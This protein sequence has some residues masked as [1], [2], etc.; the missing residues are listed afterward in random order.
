MPTCDVETFTS[1]IASGSVP[2]A[3]E[4]TLH[5]P[6]ERHSADAL[7]TTTTVSVRRHARKEPQTDPARTILN[8]SFAHHATTAVTAVA[9]AQHAA[10]KRL[11][12]PGTITAMFGA[13]ARHLNAARRPSW[14]ALVASAVAAGVLV[15]WV[16]I[17]RQPDIDARAVVRDN[18]AAADYAVRDGRYSEPT[19]RS[20]L[21]YYST[22]LAIDPMNVEAISGIDRIAD[23]YIDDA[24]RLILDGQY[25]PAALALEKVR[26]IRPE[27]RR[28]PLLDAQLRKELKEILAQAHEV[29][30]ARTLRDAAAKEAGA[31]KTRRQKSA[32]PQ[33]KLS[34]LTAS[35]V[36]A[37]AAVSTLAQTP[38]ASP[39][40]DATPTA[41]ATP[42]GSEG[43]SRAPDMVPQASAGNSV[44]A[45]AVAENAGADKSMAGTATPAGTPDAASAGRG[46]DEVAVAAI[47]VTA[48]AGSAS[49][50]AVSPE[51][52]P[53]A[54][55]PAPETASA[56]APRPQ[57]TLL[58]FVQPE[59]PGEALM[60]GYE[61]WVDLSLDV[62][63]AGVVL[64]PRVEDTSS[65][66]IFN[67]AALAA[68]RQWR[69]QPH[70]AGGTGEPEH[71][72]V[73]VEFKLDPR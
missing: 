58:R 32:D 69:Y 70:D 59:Y 7:S 67:R 11:A 44:A 24:K 19:E 68:V 56:P 10:P 66:R 30:A 1:R 46:P 38:A 8:P 6:R 29:S 33:V 55:T 43:T 20:A 31:A 3:R 36:P 13:A 23:H 61:G 47:P 18:L 50:S 52:P 28:L 21:H 2:R 35:L 49:G 45:I 40:A 71:I 5:S 54:A 34:G 72:K 14:I 60:R 17:A 64:N 27:H 4:S 62:T 26:G 15:W 65:G 41:L 16:M 51:S 63:P 22:V 73:R 37:S 39:A 25:A 9:R 12:P 53:P 48:G 57:R 42:T